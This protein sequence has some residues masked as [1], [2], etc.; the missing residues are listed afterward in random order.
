MRILTTIRDDH[1][2][3]AGQRVALLVNGLG[4]T[5]PMELAIIGRHALSV[6]RGW[7]LTVERAWCGNFLT[8]LEMPG[9]SLS[10]MSLDADRLSRLDAPT[11]APA[12]PGAGH[13]PGARRVIAAPS[14][15]AQGADSAAVDPTLRDMAHAV[16]T[17]LDAAEAEL[18]A[19]DAIAGDGDLGISLVR[20]AAAIRA[21][22]DVAWSHPARSLTEVAGALRR[23]IGGS[24]GP[25][26]ATALL[27]ASTHLPSDGAPTEQDWSQAFVGAIAAIAELGG[28]RRGDRTMLDALHPAADA[29]SAALDRG[30]ALDAAWAE[31][32][33]AAEAGLAATASMHPRLGR[34]SYLGERAIGNPDAGAAGVVV[35][36][37]AMGG[38]GR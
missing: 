6:L 3:R 18:T 24:S 7:G 38:R 25:F 13:I 23:A 37:R 22:P 28:A 8:A 2:L 27:R 14:V 16:A 5:P 10:V 20:G 36:M 29:F 17:A 32:I 33:E 26:Y 35:W 11:S 19:L 12:W 4:G 9:C 15:N 21:L 1:G 31:A 34:A 30:L